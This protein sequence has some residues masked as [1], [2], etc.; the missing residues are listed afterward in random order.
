[1]SKQVSEQEFQDSIQYYTDIL[2][3]AYKAEL[4]DS[5]DLEYAKRYFQSIFFLENE[6]VPYRS[7]TFNELRFAHNHYTRLNAKSSYS[8]TLELLSEIR[9]IGKSSLIEA[10][11]FSLGDHLADLSE[12][13]IAH[14][15]KGSSMEELIQLEELV[16]K[17]TDENLIAALAVHLAGQQLYKE[18]NAVPAEKRTTQAKHQ[19]RF[20]RNEQIL[21]T[22][23]LMKSLGVNLY[24][25]SDRT[26]MAALFHLIM[27]VPYESS[28]KL[29]D[30]SIYKGLSVVPQVVNDD[31]Q[32]MKYLKKIRPYF[33]NANFMKAVELIDAQISGLSSE[34]E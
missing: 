6:M 30:L 22:Y 28:S 34:M 1:M 11:K 2:K 4:K 18:F 26:K 33:F 19:H 24:Q 5:T 25:M 16:L 27:G 29:K 23:F 8:K 21:A 32:L 9:K 7:A 20:T 13:H 3:K 31:K 17:S 15:E 10:R 14:L 12:W